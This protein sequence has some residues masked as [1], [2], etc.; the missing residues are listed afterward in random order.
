MISSKSVKKNNLKSQYG[1]FYIS[2][3]DQKRPK[4]VKINLTALAPNST[5]LVSRAC[6]S[7][8]VMSNPDT[9]YYLS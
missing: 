9:T 3:N 8:E 6:K 7:G 1:N 5:V 4:R 2:E